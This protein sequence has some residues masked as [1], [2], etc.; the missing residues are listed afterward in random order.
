ME[1][2][3]LKA[4]LDAVDAGLVDVIVVYKVDRLTRSPRIV[5]AI[6]EGAQPRKLNRQMLLKIDLPTDWSEQERLLGFDS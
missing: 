4:L 5:E 2:P 6:V 3:G 1:R